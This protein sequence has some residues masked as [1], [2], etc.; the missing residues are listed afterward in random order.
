MS[1]IPPEITCIFSYICYNGIRSI[2]S[3]PLNHEVISM[4]SAISGYNPSTYGIYGS[5]YAH[6]QD[7]LKAVCRRYVRSFEE[8]LH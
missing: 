8:L 7:E 2:V 3:H 1:Q 6:R 4:I 5:Y